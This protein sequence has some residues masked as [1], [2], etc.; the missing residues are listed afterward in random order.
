MGARGYI[1]MKEG[2]ASDVKR[3][4]E[5]SATSVQAVGFNDRHRFTDF[6]NAAS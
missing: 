4:G 1:E 5:I 6:N 3:D 2:C